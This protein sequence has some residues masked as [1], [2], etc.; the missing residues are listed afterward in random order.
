MGFRGPRVQIPPSRLDKLKSHNQ[1]CGCGS[2]PPTSIACKSHPRVA[3]A[4]YSPAL[5]KQGF[6]CGTISIHGY[7]RRARMQS[8]PMR[9]RRPRQESEVETAGSTKVET[10]SSHLW[11]Y[12]FLTSSN[13][14]DSFPVKTDLSSCNAP[15][16]H[17]V[18]TQTDKFVRNFLNDR[19]RNRRNC[20]NPTR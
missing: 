5:K 13:R 4:A 18:R 9:A 10:I 6:L 3:K 19:D 2:L 8:L 15:A 20:L 11:T 14:L 12:P 17:G 16:R 1:L 7:A